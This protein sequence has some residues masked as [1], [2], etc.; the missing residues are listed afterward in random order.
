MELGRQA[1]LNERLLSPLPF[2]CIYVHGFLQLGYI[3]EGGVTRQTYG[4]DKIAEVMNTTLTERKYRFFTDV[5][6]MIVRLAVEKV[7]YRIMTI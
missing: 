6:S 5:D 4:G 1:L 3:V 7:R 2:L